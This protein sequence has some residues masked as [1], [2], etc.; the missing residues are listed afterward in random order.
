MHENDRQA[1]TGLLIVE[2]HAIVSDDVRHRVSSI[3]RL[4]GAWPGHGGQPSFWSFSRFAENYERKAK[5]PL[6][7]ILM[8]IFLRNAV[9]NSAP[10]KAKIR[11]LASSF[12]SLINPPWATGEP[13]PGT[14]GA[15]TTMPALIAVSADA[16]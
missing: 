16:G 5:R 7:P 8:P 13:G 4:A 15:R 12:G 10:I 11:S 9:G 6:L 14:T 2:F 1:F 3:W